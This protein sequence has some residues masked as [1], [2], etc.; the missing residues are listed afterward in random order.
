MSHAVSH[1]VTTA[2]SCLGSQATLCKLC[3]HTVLIHS[4]ELMGQTRIVC[5]DTATKQV[6]SAKSL[7]AGIST[8][9]IHSLI[10]KIA[11]KGLGRLRVLDN[12][13]YFDYLPFRKCVIRRRW[14]KTGTWRKQHQRSRS[15][16]PRRLAQLRSS[17]HQG[18][19][20]AAIGNR[21]I[22]K[23][24]SNPT[25]T[26]PEGLSLPGQV[27]STLNTGQH[28]LSAI[29]PAFDIKKLLR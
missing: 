1:A 24:I 6:K 25:R 2:R 8:L 10:L 18:R 7:H 26:T 21:Q 4:A 11:S 3:A 5:K 15:P 17:F 12:L 27:R 28:P 22:L 20:H 9:K 16:P 19:P 23:R 13:D 29:K 14:D